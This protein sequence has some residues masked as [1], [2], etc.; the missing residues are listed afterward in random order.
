MWHEFKEA[1]KASVLHC[2]EPYI[3]ALAIFVRTPMT[4]L[5]M[6]SISSLASRILRPR[7][8]DA[9]TC[10]LRKASSGREAVELYGL[11]VRI[12]GPVVRA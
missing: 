8:I 1:M 9:D 5:R 6:L 10:S 3:R 4:L 12:C 7:D 11:H 2:H